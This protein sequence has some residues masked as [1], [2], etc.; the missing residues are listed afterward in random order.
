MRALLLLATLAGC[1]AADA[2][3]PAGA[4]RPDEIASIS[5]EGRGVPANTLRESL[6]SKPG[7]LLDDALLAQDRE[8]LRSALVAQGY[9]AATVAAPHITYDR[10][11]AAFV[12]F[13]VTRGPLYHVRSVELAG[14]TAKDAGIVTIVPG[15]PVEA[16]H[17]ARARQAVAARLA[18]RGKHLDLA[19]QLHPDDATATVDVVLDAK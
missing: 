15:D 14:A 3:E 6:A 13:A 12:S 17:I 19:V 5:I 2:A 1:S 8:T 11:G 18:A 4:V 16:D 9:L 10:R 7:T